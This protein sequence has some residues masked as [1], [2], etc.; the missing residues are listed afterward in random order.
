MISKVYED[1]KIPCEKEGYYYY[2][3]YKKIYFLKILIYK[4]QIGFEEYLFKG[5]DY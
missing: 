2:K 4:K 3:Y 5:C 1:V